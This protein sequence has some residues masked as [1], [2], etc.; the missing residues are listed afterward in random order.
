M[1]KSKICYILIIAL[2]NI[3]SASEWQKLFDGKTLN[4]WDERTKSGS[5]EVIDGTIVG[6]MILDKGTTFLVY[7]KDFSDFE[8]E[9]EINIIDSELNSGVQIR[10]ACKEAKGK[11]KFGAVYGPQIE[12]A[13]KGDK[14]R[15]GFIF[16]Q[17]WKGWITPKERETNSYMKKAT[18]NKVRCV[19][20]GKNIKTWINGQFVQETIIPNERHATN[21]KGFIALQCH[22]IKSGGPYKVAWKNIRIKELVEA[23]K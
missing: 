5:F 13:T 16:G 9:F 8:L 1:I 14:T 18:W 23:K 10:S 17:G 6:T 20:I 19:A 2:L 22:G 4:G 21:S 15:S 12:L 7:D 11:Q 3:S